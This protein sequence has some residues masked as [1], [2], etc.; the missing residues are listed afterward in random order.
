MLSRKLG[1]VYKIE[2]DSGCTDRKEDFERD[3]DGKVVIV[4]PISESD[5]TLDQKKQRLKSSIDAK[6]RTMLEAKL[7]TQQSR[8][9]SAL[10]RRPNSS[11]KRK[12]AAKEKKR[13]DEE[14]IR[15]S[16]GMSQRLANNYGNTPSLVR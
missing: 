3:K 9:L 10:A 16:M 14:R 8:E 15:L 7:K 13:K 5:K 6:R 1:G 11:I 12:D 2:G 4:A